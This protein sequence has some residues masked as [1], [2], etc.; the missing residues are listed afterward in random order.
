MVVFAAFFVQP[1]L[2]F[3]NEKTHCSHC[4]AHTTS[5]DFSR[6]ALVTSR[7]YSNQTREVTTH[8]DPYGPSSWIGYYH[9]G[10]SRALQGILE[11]FNLLQSTPECSI[12]LCMSYSKMDFTYFLGSRCTARKSFAKRNEQGH[13][14]HAKRPIL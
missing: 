7:A 2:H 13:I 9:N 6:D 5:D 10:K 1:P 8:E 12:V 14:D 3:P 11:Y 4:G